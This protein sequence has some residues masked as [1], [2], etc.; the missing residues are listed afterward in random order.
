MTG[1]IDGAAGAGLVDCAASFGM[2]EQAAAAISQ[3][4]RFNSPRRVSGTLLFAAAMSISRLGSISIFFFLARL[5]LSLQDP[6]PDN[7]WE[8]RLITESVPT[9]AI[10]GRFAP[11]SALHDELDSLQLGDILRGVSVNRDDIGVFAFL[12]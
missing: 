4:A 1:L 8:G 3:L 6:P 12:D 10:L 11:L 2:P 7:N 5:I 9:A